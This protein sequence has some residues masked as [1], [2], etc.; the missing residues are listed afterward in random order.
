MA[1]KGWIDRHH[2]GTNHSSTGRSSEYKTNRGWIYHTRQDPRRRLC[3]DAPET[4]QHITAG[5]KIVAGRVHMECHNQVSGIVYRNICAEY[6]LEVQRSMWDTAPK[7]MENDRAKILWDFQIQRDKM[8]LVFCLKIS[9]NL[10]RV[11]RVRA[12]QPRREPTG[13][14]RTA[15]PVVPR[16]NESHRRQTRSEAQEAEAGR[17]RRRLRRR[18]VQLRGQGQE[19]S[20]GYRRRDARPV[21]PARSL[22]YGARRRSCGPATRGGE[23]ALSARAGRSRALPELKA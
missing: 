6:G 16:K 23:R 19:R 4:I 18:G 20:P 3:R 2:R 7:V 15:V 22:P 14:A 11:I 12:R 13:A 17:R 21:R 8:A 1:G 9:T 5:C 10:H